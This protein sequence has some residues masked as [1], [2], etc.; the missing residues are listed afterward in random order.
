MFCNHQK[1]NR[2]QTMV[3]EQPALKTRK[4]VGLFGGSFNPVHCAHLL[5]A[6][7]VGHTLG[8]QQ[9]QL[10]PSYQPPHVD[11]KKT[12][13]A[14][15]R[16]EM[17]RLATEDNPFLGIETIELMRKGVSYTF[18]TIQLLKEKNPETDYFFIIGGDM[19]A[20]LPKWY[21]IDELLNLVQFVGVARENYPRE[22]SYP[23]IWVDVPTF[24]ISSTL[25]RQR[26]Q[27]GASVKYLL[28]DKVAQYIQAKGLYL[29]D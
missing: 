29:N 4:Q 8:L 15:H 27:Q 9:V 10:L 14:K 17:L 16:L 3:K 11:A 18:D 22:S 26:V 19:V 13:D 23:I 5:I 2:T 24:D 25:I 7:E 28:P 20:Y 6:E 21:R 12:I 1:M